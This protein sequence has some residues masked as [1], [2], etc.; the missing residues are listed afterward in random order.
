MYKLSK[1]KRAWSVTPLVK[2]D[3]KGKETPILFMLLLEPEGEIKTF[4]DRKNKSEEMLNKIA[5]FLN[6]E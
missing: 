5:K 2:V 1:T 3:E 4:F 6:N